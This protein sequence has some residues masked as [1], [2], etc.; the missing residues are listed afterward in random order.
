MT[1]FDQERRDSS[2]NVSTISLTVSM[3]PVPIK[4]P[5]PL[6]CDAFDI[7][8]DDGT[9]RNEGDAYPRIPLVYCSCNWGRAI[10]TNGKYCKFILVHNI[11]FEFGRNASLRKR[12]VFHHYWLRMQGK[13]HAFV[14]VVSKA[15][16][17]HHTLAAENTGTY[18]YVPAG[19]RDPGWGIPVPKGNVFGIIVKAPVRP[20]FYIRSREVPHQAA[21]RELRVCS[22]MH[23][24]NEFLSERSRFNQRIN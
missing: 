10:I 14:F 9:P 7:S 6:A 3:M 18:D 1:D 4:R 12:V 13:A 23:T 5:N 22:R 8:S 19:F 21:R 20:G 11:R 24:T 15:F 2:C 16:T 17:R